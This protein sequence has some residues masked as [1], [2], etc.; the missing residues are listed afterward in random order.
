MNEQ[1]AQ[2]IGCDPVAFVERPWSKPRAF[3]RALIFLNYTTDM[4]GS[5][6]VDGQIGKGSWRGFRQFW[7]ENKIDSGVTDGKKMRALIRAVE[8]KI[9]AQDPQTGSFVINVEYLD[10]LDS[11]SM[12]GTKEMWTHYYDDF[13]EYL[14]SIQSAI[15]P[16]LLLAIARVETAGIARVRFEKHIWSRESCRLDRE[17]RYASSSFGLFQIMGF[18]MLKMALAVDYLDDQGDLKRHLEAVVKF[19]RLTPALYAEMVM[20]VPNFATIAKWYN[21]KNYSQ[22]AYDA[23]LRT[24]HDAFKAIREDMGGDED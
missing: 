6:V 12:M 19:L 20:S 13:V 21:G 9:E 24:A 17:R 18:N 15:D 22:N 8:D 23:K 7:N 1:I 16:T 10:R 11:G 4:S 14:D 5:A 3:Q 2:I